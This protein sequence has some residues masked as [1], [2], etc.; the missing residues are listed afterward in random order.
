[1]LYCKPCKVK[2]AGV[3]SRCPLCGGNLAGEPEEKRS[4]SPLPAGGSRTKRLIQVLSS[5]AVT[6]AILC[7]AV[8]MLVPSETWWSLF[9]VLGIACG[10]LWAVVGIVKKSKLLNSIVWQCFLISALAFLWDGLTGWHRWSAE[11]V[12]PCVCIGAML[13]V[14][15][16]SRVFRMPG[17]DYLILLI[18]CAVMGVVPLVFLFTGVLQ[19]AIPSVICAAVSLIVIFIQLIFNGK[20]MRRE[21]R[22]KLHL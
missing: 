21:I 3:H 18:V 6:G 17:K 2:V 19:M 22:K 16:L 8:N 4:Y 15:V 12:F 13:A 9:A 7:V 11:Y 5:A 10:W 1:M 20:A 14:I